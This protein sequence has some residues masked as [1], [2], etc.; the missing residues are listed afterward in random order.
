ADAE[1][2]LLGYRV[3]YIFDKGGLEVRCL[4]RSGPQPLLAPDRVHRS[5]MDEGQEERSK[6]APRGVVGLGG[7]PEREE[8]VVDHV[9]RQELGADETVGQTVGGPGI[10]PVQRVERFPIA[11]R[12]TP[13]ELDIFEVT[14]SHGRILPDR[15]HAPVRRVV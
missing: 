14:L 13:L 5:V 12:E 7:A 8:G 1:E 11:L 2:R 6:G 15:Y 3:R 10:S 9:L 4:I